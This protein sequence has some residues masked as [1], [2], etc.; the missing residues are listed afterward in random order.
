MDRMGK[1]AKTYRPEPAPAMLAVPPP[2]KRQTTRRKS[3]VGNGCFGMTRTQF[4]PIRTQFR[5][6]PG[7]AWGDFRL[8]GRKPGKYLGK[9]PF[10][11]WPD[12]PRK[13][14]YP[15]NC[16]PIVSRFRLESAGT[17]SRKTKKP[18]ENLG[19]LKLPRLDSNQDKES[20]NL[21]CYRYTTG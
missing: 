10:G 8:S 4:R 18:Q 16:V 2:V 5:V 21:L 12:I 9:Y 1:T 13:S 20:Q 14:E 6:A 11:Y 7:H 19:F 17:Q 15:R 3:R